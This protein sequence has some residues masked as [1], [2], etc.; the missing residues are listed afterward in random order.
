MNKTASDQ[1]ISTIR[2]RAI[3]D[4]ARNMM[5]DGV[6]L[7]H[8][9]ADDIGVQAIA[10]IEN[11]LGLNVTETDSGIECTPPAHFTSTRVMELVRALRDRDDGTGTLR[12]IVE[13]A[14]ADNPDATVADVRAIA[15][16]AEADAIAEA[17]RA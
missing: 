17:L 14:L 6:N 16:E 10:W 9:Q 13:H 3:N 5:A 7:T 12:V 4:E 15:L 8:A 1:Q 2:A 11:R